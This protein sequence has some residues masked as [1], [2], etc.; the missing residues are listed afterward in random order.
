MLQTLSWFYRGKLTK[1]HSKYIAR[2]NLRDPTNLYV[3]I[4]G[5]LTRI[6]IDFRL[7]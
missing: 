1:L 4:L 5:P 6:T 2:K 7:C 3:S